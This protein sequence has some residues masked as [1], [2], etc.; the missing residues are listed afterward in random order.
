VQGSVGIEGNDAVENILGPTGTGTPTPPPPV[1][2]PVASL[3]ADYTLPAKKKKSTQLP[4]LI[5]LK[6]CQTYFFFRYFEED[7][8]DHAVATVHTLGRTKHTH[9]HIYIY[10]T[11]TNQTDG[12]ISS[13]YAVNTF[14]LH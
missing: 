4:K 2:K 11:C 12:P 13:L 6:A 3:Y 7:N 1:V 9:T 5:L 8:I 14:L 10:I